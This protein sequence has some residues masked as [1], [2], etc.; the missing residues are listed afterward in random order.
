[1]EYLAKLNVLSRIDSEEIISGDN[2]RI[3]NILELL[4]YYDS[5]NLKEFEKKMTQSMSN[6]L[7]KLL[8]DYSSYVSKKDIEENRYINE[9][10]A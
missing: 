8:P 3:E 5:S 2:E 10:N 6:F 1:M 4:D 7:S 9:S